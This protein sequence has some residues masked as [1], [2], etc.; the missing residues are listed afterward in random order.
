MEI[1][2]KWDPFKLKNEN[3]KYWKYVMYSLYVAICALALGLVVYL[4][5]G[6]FSDRGTRLSHYR[7]RVRTWKKLAEDQTLD[8]I[9][10]AVKIMPSENT[11]GNMIVME[12]RKDTQLDE[13]KI[14][15]K[16]NYSQSYFYHSNTTMYFP[17]FHYERENVPVGNS[18]I[19]C[20]H[21]FWTPVE[22]EMTLELYESLK[23]FPECRKAKNPRVI[24]RQ[25]DPT[26]GAE[27][28]AWQQKAT[29]LTGCHS[30][31]AC[32]KVCDKSGGIAKSGSGKSY[33]C[34]TYKVVSEI[35][36]MMHYNGS[37]SWTYA[38]GCFENGSPVKMVPAV[39]GESYTFEHI[40]V[41]IRSVH[42]PYVVATFESHEDEDISLGVDVD[43]LYTFAFL[44]VVLAIILGIL[45]AAA[46]LLKS[47]I[48]ETSL[49]EKVCGRRIV[50]PDGPQDQF[51]K[52]ND[53]PPPKDNGP[54][55][56]DKLP[57]VE[58][59]TPESKVDPQNMF[60]GSNPPTNP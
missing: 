49:F 10:V 11:R 46:V 18:E 55:K 31:E 22:N 52:L 34:F 12:R 26:T 1:L 25:H 37:D 53:E 35:C 59:Q 15:R 50:S 29:P 19:Y 38:G 42:D 41:Q 33:I 44:L 30:H 47:R 54:P 36:L 51:G 24:W 23:G 40:R 20:V 45:V 32:Q 6:I 57:Q 4:M 43:F 17:V 39:P 56:T 5:L 60:A 3:E 21:T 14:A 58:E 2:R 7:K 28:L 9:S 48:Y 16:Y 13:Q 27:I 8:A